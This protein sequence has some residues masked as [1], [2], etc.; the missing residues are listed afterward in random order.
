MKRLILTSIL[1]LISAFAFAAAVT[2][3][4][5]L[6]G[7]LKS[8]EMSGTGDWTVTTDGSC[9]APP[10]T[11]PVVSQSCPS[12]VACSTMA[13]P[14]APQQMHTQRAGDVLALKIK[15]TADG[16]IGKLAT[17]YTSGNAGSRVI[18]LSSR[19]GDFSV[20]K[21]C[22]TTGTQITTTSWVQGG[23]T[24]PT[25][26][27][28]LPVNGEFWVNIKHAYCQGSCEFYLKTY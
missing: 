3:N 25:Y 24:E 7:S 23:G 27:C 15:T 1:T 16:V 4:G 17:A 11:L 21:E 5:V 20:P 28:K 14:N 6:C 8:L 22:T 12:G 19:P 26:R 2:V 13:W 10:V 18:A 9:V